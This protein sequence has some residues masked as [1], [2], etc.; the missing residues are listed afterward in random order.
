MMGCKMGCFAGWIEIEPEE[1]SVAGSGR[2]V[3]QS[4]DYFVVAL[5]RK[6]QAY[7]LLKTGSYALSMYLSGLAA[8]SILRSLQMLRDPGLTFDE[9]HDLKRLLNGLDLA[10]IDAEPLKRA[11]HASL[12]TAYV[13]WRN[14]YRYASEDKI[15]SHL[16]AIGRD[17]S[18]SGDFLKFNSK[19]LYE[20]SATIVNRGATK[21][22]QWQRR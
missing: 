20:A 13:L 6:N 17:R 14:V 16:K 2:L 11:I 12:T 22:Q 21:W 19:R 3:F 1:A 8:E 9:K 18:I 5:E 15:R 7:E 4:R 10:D